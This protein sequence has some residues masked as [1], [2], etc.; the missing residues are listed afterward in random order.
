MELGGIQI[1]ILLDYYF[2]WF[3]TSH[4]PNCIKSLFILSNIRTY[5]KALFKINTKINL[6][7]LAPFRLKISIEP[8]YF[9]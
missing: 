3:H 7:I 4:Q 2:L 8:Y 6:N 1:F 9:F 5:E